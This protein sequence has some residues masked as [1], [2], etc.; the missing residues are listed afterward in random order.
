M[1]RQVSPNQNSK[2]IF[3]ER[4]VD[5]DGDN[6]T[7]DAVELDAIDG[8][9]QSG[10]SRTP[11]WLG[12]SS[13]QNT[14]SSG[15]TEILV[16]LEIDSGSLSDNTTYTFVVE[17]SDPSIG[18]KRFVDLH[19]RE[20]ENAATQVW[21]SYHDRIYRVQADGTL[22]DNYS[23]SG[24]NQNR[25]R[26]PIA[27]MPGNDVVIGL[28]NKIERRDNNFNLIWDNQ[29]IANDTRALT[30]GTDGFLYVADDSGQILKINR[31]GT[32]VDTIAG[33][34]SYDR[35][36]P[37]II[38]ISNSNVFFAEEGNGEVRLIDGNGDL[39][40]N[41][42][43]NGVR[44]GFGHDDQ[45]RLGGAG[46]KVAVYDSEGT[47]RWESSY[48]NDNYNG[49]IAA[50]SFDP[51][52]NR[53]AVVGDDQ[54]DFRVMAHDDNGNVKWE[55]ADVPSRESNGLA[56]CLAWDEGQNVYVGAT[57]ED[58]HPHLVKIDFDGNVLYDNR[59]ENVSD[60][61]EIQVAVPRFLG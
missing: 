22:L 44:T 48:Y 51:R 5:G 34:G 2:L 36:E 21:V 29:D 39:V 17:V 16:D 40:W 26:T 10:A 18:G 60:Y 31:D 19:V 54:F 43:Q 58:Y 13:T 49:G 9:T 27:A 30:F 12:F 41:V 61:R 28:E 33:T 42:S 1:A 56:G 46:S 15:A 38:P 3:T 59:L 7:V 50:G 45:D 35:I 23:L 8:I 24:I 53:L 52:T 55:V 32:T 25:K 11:S 47:L 4:F 57:H 20:K 37:W 6:L 14:L